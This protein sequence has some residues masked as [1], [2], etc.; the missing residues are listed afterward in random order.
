M[1]IVAII[2]LTIGFAAGWL[3]CSILT[4]GRLADEWSAGYRACERNQQ[5]EQS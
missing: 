2:S 4:A 1:I 5:Q 3:M